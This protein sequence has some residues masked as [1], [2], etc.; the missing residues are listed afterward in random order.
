MGLFTTKTQQALANIDKAEAKGHMTAAEARHERHI[1]RA[2]QV[3]DAE[4]ARKYSTR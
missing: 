3:Q 1:V 4:R 2:E